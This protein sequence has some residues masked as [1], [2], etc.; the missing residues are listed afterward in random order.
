LRELEDVQ[1]F[2]DLVNHIDEDDIVFG[3]PKWLKNFREMKQAAIDPLY[4]DGGKCPDGC[5]TL[6]F[7]LQ[8]LML[9]A[10]HGWSDNSFNDLL[11]YLATTYPTGGNKVQA[12]TYRAKKLIRPVA[13]KVRKFDA[14]PNHCI[15]YQ[16]EKYEKLTRC[17]D[18]GV[19]RYKRNASCRVDDD[20]EA[21]R[22]TGGPKK[23]KKKGVK[24]GVKQILAQQDEEEEGYTRRKSP[25]LSVWYL[26]VVDR[27]CALFENPE[28]AK[29]MSWHASPDWVKDDGKLQ[30]PSDGQQWKDFDNAY[31]AF[32]DEPRHVWFALSTDGM[33]SFGELSSSHSTWSVVLTIYNLPPYL[34]QK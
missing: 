21:M 23:K 20:N 18:C 33:N 1:L 24:K 28:D 11:S 32:R 4:Q 12:N 13:M 22:C 2:E 31:P 5:T 16:G 27:L 30:H 14:C 10:R 19:N 25:A 7:N 29:L 15:M 34:C 8:L 3:S 26:P 17:P 6:R 9:N